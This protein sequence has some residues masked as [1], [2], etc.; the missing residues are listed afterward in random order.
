[1]KV[2]IFLQQLAKAE[3]FLLDAGDDAFGLR[4]LEEGAG[5]TSID[6]IVRHGDQSVIRRVALS[7]G[8]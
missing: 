1:L 8:P 7:R 5:I 4:H 2:G 6:G 3:Q